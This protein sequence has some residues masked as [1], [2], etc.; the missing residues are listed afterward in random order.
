[1]H[2]SLC[3]ATEVGL[4]ASEG[5]WGWFLVFLADFPAAAERNGATNARRRAGRGV[6]G[7]PR[8]ADVMTP[9]Y[10]DLLK[11]IVKDYPDLDPVARRPASSSLQGKLYLCRTSVPDIDERPREQCY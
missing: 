4:L 8:A 7:V 3:V 11:P 10:F 1:L 9:I 6:P 5:S 2:L